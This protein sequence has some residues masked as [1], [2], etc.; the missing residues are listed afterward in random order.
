MK[1]IWQIT[2]TVASMN[3]AQNLASILVGEKLAACV[4]I[5]G[6]I[7]SVYRWNG[8][9]ANQIEYLCTIK[10]SESS[11][12]KCLERITEAHSYD[13]PELLYS[14]ILRSNSDYLNWVY[15]QTAR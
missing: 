4:Q 9:M 5:D 8:E 7:H 13:T 14:P 6:P 2:T 12:E 10:T 11:L 3:D 15:E 1:Q